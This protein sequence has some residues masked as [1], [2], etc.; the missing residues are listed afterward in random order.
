MRRSATLLALVAAL[1]VPRAARA[2]S[3][4][5]LLERGMRAAR[6]LEYDSAAVML[7]AALG[8]TGTDALP[9]TSRGR[10]L[11]FL[12]ATEFFRDHRD[13]ATAIFGRILVLDPR[14]RP[15]Q[16]VFPPEI[17][18]L[19]QDVRAGT[20]AVGAAVPPMTEIAG[21]ADRLAVRL[22]ATSLHEIAAT[23]VRPGTA[24]G[25]VRTLYTG[26]I[27]DS[28]EVLWDGR[29]SAGAVADTGGYL[30]RVA[31]R[32]PT[33][34]VVRILEVPL[35]VRVSRRDTLPWPPPMSDSLMLPEHAPGGGA[36]RALAG[37]LL[38]AAATVIL[39]SIV[40]GGS[41]A[42]SAR[43]AVAAAT[44]VA[45][46]IGFRVSRRPQPIPA[47]ITAN[48]TLRASWQRRLDTVRAE[49]VARRRET[50]LVVRSGAAR[51]AAGP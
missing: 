23:I 15:D 26:A 38:A 43:Y 12:G 3:G 36:P 7:R 45:G 18:S 35:D 10:A 32:G 22:Y 49:N 11:M 19:F 44:G 24:G 2:Q 47:N 40:S 51:S 21:P 9:D 29:D 20:R 46:I 41:Q 6:D 39:P 31:S 25:R 1:A 30:L 42:T 34:R 17:S 28:L 37:G 27:G 13:S 4:T 33:G 5:V 16:L 48:Q 8:R 14:Y 50:R